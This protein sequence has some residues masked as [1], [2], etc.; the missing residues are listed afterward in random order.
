MSLLAPAIMV[1][2]ARAQPTITDLGTLPGTIESHAAGVSGD[3]LVVAGYSVVDH[4]T[5]NSLAGPSRRDSGPGPQSRR[6]TP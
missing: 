1:C 6:R 4:V 2:A 5:G 3:G